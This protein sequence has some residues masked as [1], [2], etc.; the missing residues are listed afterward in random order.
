MADFAKGDSLF[1][2]AVESGNVP[3]F[4]HLSKGYESTS[5]SIA[6]GIAGVGD[7][8]SAT[9]SGVDSWFKR[10]IRDEATATID[11]LRDAHIDDLTRIKYAMGDPSL[12]S[13]NGVPKDLNAQMLRLKV[14]GEARASGKVSDTQYYTQLD[15]MARGLRAKYP[16][17][18]EHID[19]VVKDVT[20]VDPAN[21]VIAELR[22]EIAG[23]VDPAEKQYDQAVTWATHNGHLPDDFYSRKAAGKPYS[24]DELNLAIAQRTKSHTNLSYNMQRLAADK[25]LNAATEEDADRTAR[26]GLNMLQNSLMGQVIGSF[27][28]REDLIKMAEKASTGVMTAEE[29][30]QM[31]ASFNQYRTR[32]I[33]EAQNF[34]NS[35]TFGD[36]KVT[37]AQLLPPAKLKELMDG[38]ENSLKFI[39]DSI[40]NKDY[41]SILAWERHNKLIEQGTE[42]SLLKQYQSI[43]LV[44]AI[45]RIA[46]D[47]L[48]SSLINGNAKLLTDV[49]R[50]LADAGTAAILEGKSFAKILQ[51]ANSDKKN[52][53][54][55]K[56]VLDNAFRIMTDP[57]TLPAVKSGVIN[58]LYGPESQNILSQ[59]DPKQHMQFWQRMT[60]PQVANEAIKLKEAGDQASWD[61]YQKWVQG[62]FITLFR[63]LGADAQSIRT[64]SSIMDLKWNEATNQFQ[65]VTAPR[66]SNKLGIRGNAYAMG[67]DTALNY[68][69]ARESIDILNSQIRGIV[70]ILQADGKPV[71]PALLNLVQGLGI[72]SNAPRQPGAF[73]SLF[74]KV[75]DVLLKTS[76]A[77]S[78]LNSKLGLNPDTKARGPGE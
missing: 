21:R 32:W 22:S 37:F 54:A 73:M 69:R 60:S 6:K 19:N 72:N 18:R 77:D 35:K 66:P 57:K 63:K 58:S 62:S 13:T 16:G 1:D 39:Q 5:S 25:A 12:S 9:V 40:Y 26:Q 36:N 20:G 76:A 51:E 29:K 41:G 3:N 46:G 7:A 4:T 68:Q 30:A 45:K 70:P 52:P 74:E 67:I 50:S 56:Q 44:G 55:T 23:R 27:G 15:I 64:S 8:V 65:V 59:I 38:H 11:T 71:G 49:Q 33:S 42:N 17:Y 78:E 34:L 47:Q 14:L 53:E 31:D 61:K 10:K 2:P 75:A 28:S 24:L 43:N 48:A